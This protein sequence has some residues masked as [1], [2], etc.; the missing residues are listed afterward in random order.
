MKKLSILLGVL[1]LCGAVSAQKS[2]KAV[3]NH[4]AVNIGAGTEGA[5]I[6]LATTC[7]N[8]LEFGFDVSVVPPFK[9]KSDIAVNNLTAGGMSV[10][11]HDVSVEGN[12]GRTL[13]NFKANCYPF[14]KHSSFFVAAGFSFGGEKMLN[15]KGHSEDIKNFIAQHPEMKGQLVSEIDKYNLA[16]S[17]NGDIV[18]DV[19]IKNFRPYLGLGF[20]R[21]I[22]K[23]R[24]G[25]R[26]EMGCQFMGKAQIYQNNQLVN[27]SDTNDANDD[28]SKIVEKM[29]VYPVLKLSI[30][31][32]IF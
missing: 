29:T 8:Y 19:R 2:D 15:L 25:C 26:F 12:F 13:C 4:L 24:V 31:T 27:A 7:T 18:G 16:F 32:R 11:V 30:A 9:L 22:P 3:F 14:G 5:S 17:D 20:G 6:G 21:L 23:R 28:I 1:F 10:P